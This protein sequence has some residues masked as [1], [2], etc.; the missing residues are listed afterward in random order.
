MRKIQYLIVLSIIF[1]LNCCDNPTEPS[2]IKRILP[3]KEGNIWVYQEYYINN[4]DSL[5][6]YRIDTIKVLSDTIVNDF[7]FYYVNYLGSVLDFGYINDSLYG[8]VDPNHKFV[9]PFLL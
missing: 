6:K 2:K 8:F 5:V 3:L 7:K 9:K 1:L 4:K